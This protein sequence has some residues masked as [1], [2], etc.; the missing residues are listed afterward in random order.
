MG[1]FSRIKLI[2]KCNRLENEVQ[3]LNETMKSETW[4]KKILK[5]LDV[6]EEVERLKR[7]NKRLKKII[8]ERGWKK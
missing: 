2:L 5:L 4:K 6:P 8:E 7:E 3:T 1:K